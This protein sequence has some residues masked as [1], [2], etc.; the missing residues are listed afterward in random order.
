MFSSLLY[1]AG[2]SLVTVAAIVGAAYVLLRQWAEGAYD[3]MKEKNKTDCDIDEFVGP[4]NPPDKLKVTMVNKMRIGNRVASK[5]PIALECTKSTHVDGL[6]VSRAVKEGADDQPTPLKDLLPS[7][8]NKTVVVATIRMGFGH[9]RIAYSA[10]SWALD[11]GYTTIFHDLINIESE[12]SKLIGSA[13]T[14]YSKMSQWSSEIG[15]PI[16]YLWGQVSRHYNIAAS[17]QAFDRGRPSIVCL[18]VSP[19]VLSDIYYCRTIHEYYYY[20]YYY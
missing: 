3:A 5:T 11:Q 19:F 8:K 14:F 18:F 2:V 7:G 15:G 13:D 20:E 9:H 1:Y 4:Q 12:E 16:E 10:C 17:R 6:Y